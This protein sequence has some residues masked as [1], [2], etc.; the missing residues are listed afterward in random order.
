MWWWI[1]LREILHK[2][3]SMYCNF[4]CKTWKW[5]DSWKLIYIRCYVWGIFRNCEWTVI[6]DM[7]QRSLL[8]GSN[9]QW[10]HIASVTITITSWGRNPV[11]NL[12]TIPTLKC[13]ET[14]STAWGL[15]FFYSWWQRNVETFCALWS[16]C[17]KKLSEY[18]PL[19]W[20]HM[21]VMTSWTTGN[22]IVCSWV[23]MKETSELHLTDQWIP[24]IMGQ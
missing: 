19:Q 6:S 3:Q 2:I 11:I 17:K 9:C 20:C 4:M 22:S 10:L 13:G 12:S 7:G 16:I 23:T 21:N 1:Y 14:T 8:I 24:L 15:W 5:S 18:I